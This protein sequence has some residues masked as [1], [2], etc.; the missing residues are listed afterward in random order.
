MKYTTY[1]ELKPSGIPWLGDVPAHWD[2]DRI[3]W[4]VKGC[5]GGLWGD[6]PEHDTKRDALESLISIALNF[7]LSQ[8]HRHYGS[9]Q[10]I[11]SMLSS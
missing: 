7:V 8:S 9:Y 5:Y 11:N 10:H 2:M 3:K 1:P 6:E 4:S